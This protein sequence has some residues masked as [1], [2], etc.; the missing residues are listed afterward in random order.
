M[1]NAHMLR[2]FDG[3]QLSKEQPI[4]H[5]EVNSR[6]D[7][8]FQEIART[9]SP[10]T[11]LNNNDMMLKGSWE[12]TPSLEVSPRSRRVLNNGD[13]NLRQKAMLRNHRKKKSGSFD[14]A[15]FKG[16]KGM[17]R[18][19]LPTKRCFNVRRKSRRMAQPYNMQS[20][21]Q[22]PNRRMSIGYGDGKRNDTFPYGRERL[23]SAPCARLGP[24]PTAPVLTPIDTPLL[25]HNMCSFSLTSNKTDIEEAMLSLSLT[26]HSSSSSSS[27]MSQISEDNFSLGSP[28]SSSFSSNN[29]KGNGF[30]W[31]HIH[32]NNNNISQQQNSATNAEFMVFDME[33]AETQRSLLDKD[34]SMLRN[35]P[36]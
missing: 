19:G 34:I 27:G 31:N 22:T 21:S 36:L 1:P 10:N 16:M 9:M 20:N 11:P 3:R 6:S 14:S 26:S 4:F 35:A 23:N 17:S 15:M 5:V 7:H 24:S 13:R 18:D 28:Y 29:V 25:A 33:I 2:P 32:N 30:G 12:T 8:A